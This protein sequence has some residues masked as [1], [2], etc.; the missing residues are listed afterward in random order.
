MSRIRDIANLFSGS[1]DAATDAEV[2]A[3][4]SA[5]NTT[6]NGHV[7]RGNTASRP[8]SPSV[9]DMYANTQTG[10]IETYTGE[11]YGWELVGVISSAVTG[12]AATNIPTSRAYN[13]G[14]ASIVFTP[15]AILGRT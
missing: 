12:V 6:A 14:S 9:G 3:A 10:F 5:H 11:T 15:G 4:V 13:N 1:T 8:A 7:K 2:S